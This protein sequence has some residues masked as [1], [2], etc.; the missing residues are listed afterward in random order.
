MQS[1]LKLPE[2]IDKTIQKELDMGWSAGP[3]HEPPFDTFVVN[4]I[5]I[6][7]KKSGGHRMI[8]DLSRPENEVNHFISKEQFSLQY[9]SIDNALA[10]L[11]SLGPEAVMC[12]IDIKDAFRLIPVR[13]ED[14]PLLGYYWEG[15][16]Y[17]HKRLPF[18]LRSSPFHFSQFAGTLAWVTKDQAQ[19]HNLIFY[20][21]DF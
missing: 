8:T 9:A 12:K 2:V 7:D 17:F 1:A 5:G 15:K 3:F 6:V 13:K 11:Q 4:S 19:T 21:D 10:I 20:L 16:Y 14:W 18:G